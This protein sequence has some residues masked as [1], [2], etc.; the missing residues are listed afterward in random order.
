MDILALLQAA[1]HK[2]VWLVTAE[3]C[4]G[5]MIA[6]ALTSCAGSSDVVAGG[7]V[8]YSNHFK[9][10]DVGVSA[11]SLRAYGAVSEIVAKEMAEGAARHAQHSLG[12]CRAVLAVAVTGIAG[13][14]GGSAEKPV[15]T[16]HMATCL[17]QVGFS[18]ILLH[19]ALY[20]QGDRDAVRLQTVDAAL[21]MMMDV[22]T[23]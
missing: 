13:P 23:S 11:E 21:R 3:S 9:Q 19:K 14:A 22:L 16:V 12:D 5:G 2:D 10:H 20:F 18:P 1:R 6:A 7:F 8:T 4:T 17:L 15:G